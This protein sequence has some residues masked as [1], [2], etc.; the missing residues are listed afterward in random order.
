MQKSMFVQSLDEGTSLFNDEEVSA[1]VVDHTY[2]AYKSNTEA[3]K[4]STGIAKIIHDE[5]G[6]ILKVRNI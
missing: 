5:N 6:D 2:G 1:T 3:K 4:L